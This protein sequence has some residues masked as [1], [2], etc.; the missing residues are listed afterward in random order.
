MG[1]KTNR[2]DVDLHRAAQSV[3]SITNNEFIIMQKEK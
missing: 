3:S 1:R 2:W